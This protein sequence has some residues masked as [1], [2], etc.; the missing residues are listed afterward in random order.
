MR[1]RIIILQLQHHKWVS[2]NLYV[3]LGVSQIQWQKNVLSWFRLMPSRTLTFNFKLARAHFLNYIL[4]A[5][6]C[7]IHLQSKATARIPLKAP[8]SG[9]RQGFAFPPI[10]STGFYHHTRNSLIISEVASA[11]TNALRC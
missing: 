11:M 7:A 8:V 5:T 3:V 2:W 6:D 1:F 9:T 10:A 4:P